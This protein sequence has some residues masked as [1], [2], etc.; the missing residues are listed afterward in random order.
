MV[1]IG[2]TG[3]TKFNPEDERVKKTLQEFAQIHQE[4][5]QIKAN[6]LRD[7]RREKE[8]ELEQYMK[9]S[10]DED[11]AYAKKMIPLMTA[12]KVGISGAVLAASA[13]SAVVFGKFLEGRSDKNK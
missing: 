8:E 13:L 1:R 12:A 3:E 6:K 2:M 5:V 10:I 11:E 9:S 4:A 7:Q